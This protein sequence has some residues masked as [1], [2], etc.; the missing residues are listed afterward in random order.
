MGGGRG[1]RLEGT[2]SPP[3]FIFAALKLQETPF[4]ESVTKHK[5]KALFQIYCS[6]IFILLCMTLGNLKT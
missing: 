4:G 1:E 5:F 6:L 3:S 2:P